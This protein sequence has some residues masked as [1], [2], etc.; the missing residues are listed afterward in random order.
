M[1]KRLIWVGVLML[2]LV[3][4]AFIVPAGMLAADEYKELRIGA[5]C[6][7][8][9]PAA[10]WG[11]PPYQ[12]MT[13]RVEEI[14]AAGGLIIGG[15]KFKVK[16]CA[17]DSKAEVAA[18]TTALEKLI[19]RDK[20]HVTWSHTAGPILATQEKIEKLHMLNFIVGWDPAVRGSKHPYTYM[21]GMIGPDIYPDF[22]GWILKNYPVKTAKCIAPKTES[23]YF[24]ERCM[25]EFLLKAGFLDLGSE[26]YETGTTDFHPLISRV[27]AAKTDVLFS[28][29]TPAQT[30][31]VLKQRDEIG[32]KFLFVDAFSNPPL[33]MRLIPQSCEKDYIFRHTDFT[34]TPQAKAFYDRYVKRWKE[35]PQSES[36]EGYDFVGIYVQAVQKAGKMDTD[37]V[38]AVW[39]DPTFEYE[40]LMGTYKWGGKSIYGMNCNMYFPI[41]VGAIKDG[42]IKILA[43]IPITPK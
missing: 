19:Y 12:A 17:E 1:K 32:A 3:W 4:V 40:G 33:M 20:V 42:N 2:L 22:Y 38:K 34:L 6:V 36:Q 35:W 23:G 9:G 16:L 21:A 11:L 28:A 29:C 25:R 18:S 15:E 39:D 8:S 13:M 14:N 30:A 5:M 7:L 26:F 10:G 24:Q 31:L 37:A 43:R 27:M 41:T